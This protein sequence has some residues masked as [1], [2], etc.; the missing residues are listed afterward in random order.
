[1]TYTISIYNQNQ[2][3]GDLHCKGITDMKF[4]VWLK[5]CLSNVKLIQVFPHI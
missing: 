2:W 4:K 5:F 3:I 1:M